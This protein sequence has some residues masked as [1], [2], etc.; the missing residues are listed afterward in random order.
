MSTASLYLEKSRAAV[1]LLLSCT[2]H[3]LMVW[4]KTTI[5]SVSSFL[6]QNSD[7]TYLAPRSSIFLRLIQMAQFPSK[8]GIWLRSAIV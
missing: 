6:K 8:Q 2:Q 1:F 4:K 7:L 5:Y 3:Q